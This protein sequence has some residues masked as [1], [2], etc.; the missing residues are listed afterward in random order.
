MRS[1][2]LALLL[3][4]LPAIATA[5]SPAKPTVSAEAT[6]V[7]R[8]K[9]DTARVV[10]TVASRNADADTASTDTD[11]LVTQFTDA[12]TKLKLAGVKA[13]SD[14]LRVDRIELTNNRGIVGPGV[15]EFNAV[16]AVVVTVSDDDPAK[17]VT[18]LEK[19]QKEAAKQ[20]V[21]G[22][23]GPASYNGF[24]YEKN[25]GVRVAYTR[26]EAG[27]EEATN[28]AVTKA[29]QRAMKKAEALATGAGLKLG[30]LVSVGELPADAPKAATPL[31]AATI[32]SSAYGGGTANP[33]VTA[34][35]LDSFIDGELVRRVKVRV[36]YATR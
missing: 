26:A 5:Q 14:P 19:V 11:T 20:N 9:P 4:A 2:H 12:L 13:T 24:Q 15:G 30:D 21:G 3:A 18:L 35:T 8:A 10:F 22:E 36:V 32:G 29:T 27:W 6:E 34:D 16:R 23:M 28:A 7:I 1:S 17:L 25:G 31:V 33:G